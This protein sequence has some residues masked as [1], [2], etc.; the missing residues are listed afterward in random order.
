M[1]EWSMCAINMTYA[2]MMVLPLRQQNEKLIQE[3]DAKK[4]SKLKNEAELELLKQNKTKC[5]EEI[6]SSNDEIQ[7]YEKQIKQSKAKVDKCQS[8]YQGLADEKTRWNQS[9]Q[10]HKDTINKIVGDCILGAAFLT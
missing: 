5:D 6:K 2:K 9:V 8:I 7:L 1:A 10:N 4:K 3:L